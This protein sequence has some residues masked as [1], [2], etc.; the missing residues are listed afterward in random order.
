VPINLVSFLLYLLSTINTCQLKNKTPQLILS[1]LKYSLFILLFATG[2]NK[3]GLTDK[4]VTTAST[5]STGATKSM[6]LAAR[7]VTIVNPGFEQGQTGWANPSLFSISTSTFHSGAQS[8]KLTNTT[9]KV[10]QTITV[11]ADSMVTLSAWIKGKGTLGASNG[12]TTLA[13]SSGTYSNWTQVTVTFNPGTATSITIY[14]TYNGGVGYFD[15][16]TMNQGSAAQTIPA[17]PGNLITTATGATTV[18]VTWIDSSNNET[19]FSVER[20][21][22]ATGTYAVIAANIAANTTSYKDTGLTASTIY[23]YRARSFNSAGYSNYSNQDSAITA[24]LPTI[25]KAPGNLSATATGTTTVTVTWVDSSNNETG[26]SLERKTGATGTYAVIAGNIAANT[27]SYKD[28]GLTAATVYYY[29]ARSF[30]SAGYSAYSNAASVTTLSITIPAAPSNLSATASNATTVAITWKDNSNNETGFSLERK[31]GAAG[32]YAQ[33]AGS[34]PANTTSYTDNGLTAGTLYYYRARSFNTAG[35]S[36]YSNETSV[37]TPTAGAYPAN[38]LNLTNW[39]ITLPIDSK[40]TQTGSAIEIDQPQL[41]TYSI[42]PYFYNDSDNSGVIFSANCGGSTTS[43][44]DYPRSELREMTDNGADLA[45]WTSSSGTS[46]M[47][48]DQAVMHLPVVKPQIVVGQIHGPSDDI[49]T[50]RLEGSHL[51]MDHNGTSGTTLDNNYVLG[52]RFK[53][54]FIVSNNEVQS[55]YNDVLMETYPI[56][57]SGA[58]FKAGAY[59]QSTCKNNKVPGES[60]SAYGEVIIYSVTVTHQ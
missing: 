6:I 38:I 49:I 40:G 16:F 56:S 10:A 14:G 30:N 52:T 42:I 50:F 51:F 45:S 31:T 46:T 5:Q 55:Y 37:T 3:Q 15:D 12:F 25:P 43:G 54:K 47:E 58:Y 21:T 39:K 7:P 48:I 33:I 59:V 8:A 18:T 44:S 11:T 22:G 26:F 29:R 20:K 32:T 13:S 9:N 1:A 4:D 24:S 41:A 23:Y 53:A 36:S 28:T 19:G 27:T 34:I 60:C 35:Y 2:C 57:F 17:A